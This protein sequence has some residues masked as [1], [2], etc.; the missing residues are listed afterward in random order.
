MCSSTK[1]A[2]PRVDFW[3]ENT[4]YG[5]QHAQRRFSGIEKPTKGRNRDGVWV[6][7]A[8]VVPVCE[9]VNYSA[10]NTRADSPGVSIKPLFLVVRMTIYHA[11]LRRRLSQYRTYSHC[12]TQLSRFIIY[13]ILFT[14]SERFSYRILN[15]QYE[16]T[17]IIDVFVCPNK[18][19]IPKVHYCTPHTSPGNPVQVIYSAK[20]RYGRNRYDI[21]IIII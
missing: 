20:T 7:Q 10:P 15:L 1:N 21:I 11:N 12:R 16:C 17:I 14:V 6:L 19:T 18:K 4:S 3:P 13:I 5:S 9:C 8:D 2:R